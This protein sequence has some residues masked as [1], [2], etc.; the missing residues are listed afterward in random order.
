M[1]MRL[2]SLLYLICRFIQVNCKMIVHYDGSFEGFLTLVY[3]VYYCHLKPTSITKQEPKVLLFEPIHYIFTD[4]SKAT[5][6]LQSIKK[7]FLPEYFQRLFYTFLC[8]SIAFEMDLLHFIVL[9]FRDQKSLENITIPAI[10]NLQ[11]LMQTLFKVADKMYGFTRFEELSDGSLYAKVETKF[12]LLPL[13]GSHFSKRL[14]AYPF[15]IHDV[16]RSLAYIKNDTQTSIQ[17]VA[18]FETPK[19]SQNELDTLALWKTFFKHVSIENR[20]NTKLQKSHVPLLYRT[21]MSEFH[22]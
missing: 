8:D 9:G 11:C 3:E 7:K 4:K 5:K 14:G 18:S 1:D 13:L 17:N 16:K 6:V 12:N 15:I 20:R 2:S 21:Y 22:P 19:V 10:F